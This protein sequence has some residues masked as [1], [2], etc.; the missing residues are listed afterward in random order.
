MRR[1]TKPSLRIW[2]TKRPGRASVDPVQVHSEFTTK[3]LALKTTHGNS[4]TRLG[5][6][7][8]GEPHPQTDTWPAQQIRTVGISPHSRREVITP[9]ECKDSANSPR[10]PSRVPDYQPTP[11]P[12]A[13]SRRDFIRKFA[14]LRGV[15]GSALDAIWRSN[16]RGYNAAHDAHFDRFQ[17][18]WRDTKPGYDLDPVAILPGDLVAFL[19]Q[20]DS[21]GSS[22]ASIKDASAS[23]SMA[24]R[25][26][27]DGEVA[28]GDKESVKRFLK[29]L[30]IHAP[31]G[32]RKQLV[33]NYHDVAALYQEAWDFGPNE[34]LC[35]GHLKEK[36]I[37]LLMV[38]TAARP[39]DIHRL[40]RTLT[41]RNAQIRF[42]G[43]DL[44]IRY[45]W[46]KE[47]DPGS[48]RSNSTNIYFSKWVKIHGTMPRI[49]DTVETM[50]TFLQRTSD[51]EL[52]ATVHIPELQI[53]A[54]PLIYARL[55]RGKL[56]HSS[57]DH[58]SNIMRRAINDRHL[59][60]MM[61]AHIRGASVSKIV[62]LA[63]ELTE[64]ALA[65]GR[66]TTPHTFRNHYQA[67]VLGTWA[68]LPK[69]IMDN[70]QQILR[71]GW[72]RTPPVNVSVAEYEQHP[73]YWVGRSIPSL[74][75]IST[76]DNG[77]YTVNNT[78]LKHW[79]LMQ[80]IS[81]ARNTFTV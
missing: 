38:D 59:G 54:Q 48:S 26:A 21:A 19:Q 51:P 68:K 72:T 5:R 15:S 56:Q 69:S 37:I 74:G 7:L 77:D 30:R 31:V 60:Q 70:P 25:E 4:D 18:F 58:I 12:T 29:S 3:T 73:N 67:P 14:L 65:L 79:E 27:T 76:F 34:A 71:W 66:W 75:K 78:I 52:Y 53:S 35:E 2:S 20:M 44:F 22:F 32:P 9:V 46:S 13:L 47:V 63:P 36:L 17:T 45:F 61:T 28:L 8:H 24:C 41:G 55:E 80:L 40:F 10:G 49:T 6:W 16:K 11:I 64:Q 1:G 50:R 33:P 42:E 62:Q 43:K 23:I 39:S 81:E 57:V